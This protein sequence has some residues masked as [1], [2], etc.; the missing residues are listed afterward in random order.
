LVINAAT[1]TYT[2]NA[3]SMTYGSAVPG[4]SGSVS[5]F[6]GTDNQGNAT[7]GTLTFTPATTSTSGVGSYAI[8]GTGL[9]ANNGNYTFVQATGNATA[10]TINALPVNL[11]GTRSYDGTTTAAAGILSVANKVGSDNVTVVSGNGTLAGANV[12]SKAITSLGTLAL[13]GTAA[14]NYTLA[15]ASGSVNITVSALA[16]TVTNL[17]ALDNVYDGTTNATLDATN[18]GL[19]GVLNGDSVTLVVSNAVA[20]F[21]DKNVGTNKPVTVTGLALGSTAAANYTLADPTNVTANITA[22]GLTVNGVAAASKVYDGTTNA[23]LNGTATLNGEVS[24]DDVSLVTDGVNAAFAGP[25]VGTG[26]PVTVRGYAIT[27]ADAGNYTLTQPSALAADITAATLTITATA[28]TKTYD[29]TTSASA[30]PTTSG[31]QGSDTV[32]GLAETYDTK[33]VGTGK[34]LSVNAYTVN[35]GNSGNNYIVNTATSTAGVISKATLTITAT[36]NTKTY[37]GS[38]SAAT[39]PTVSGL[40]GSDTVTGLAETYDTKHAGT[41]KTLSVSAYTVNDSN[42]GNNYTVSTAT[43]TAGVISQASLTITAAANTKTYDC[44]ISASATPT[45]SGLQGSDSVSGLAE[46]YDTKNVGSSKTLSVNAYTVN[47]GNN[48]NNYTVSTVASTAGVINAATLTITAAANTKTYDSSTSAAATPTTSGLQGSD[49]VTGLTE[50]YDTKNVGTGK[51]LSVSAYTVNDGNSGANYTVSTATSIA[52]VISK[53]TLT[54]TATANTKIY[55]GSTSSAATPTVSGLQDS[56]TVTGLAETYDTKNVGTDKTLSVS[57][58]T[59]NDGNNGNNYTVSTATSTAG[60]I[61]KATLTITAAT[62]TKIYDGTTSAA[63]IPTASGLQSSDT[64][65]GLAETYDTK[66]VGSGKTINVSAYTVNDGNAGGNYTVSTVANTA[67]IINQVVLTITAATNTKIYDGSTSAA[68]SPTTSGLQVS[69]SVTGLAETYDTKNVG[70]GKTLSVSAFTVNDGNNG[71]NYTVNTVASTAG[72]I[73]QAFLTITA[74]AN[75][76][77]YDCSISASATPTVSGLQGSDSV[78][79]LAETYDTKNVGS[80]KTLSVNVYTVNDGNSGGN[81]TVSTVASTA[82]VI[83]PAMLTVTADN[84]SKMCGQPNPPLTASYNG[85]VNGE[86][87]NVLTSLVTLATTATTS[88]GAGT[89]P[90]TASGAAAANYTINY[91]GGQLTV[92]SVPQLTGVDINVNGNNLFIISWPTVTG[93]TYQLEYKDDLMAAAWTPEGSSLPGND[94]MAVVTNNI[95]DSPQRFFRVQ[96]Q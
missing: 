47:D 5:G 81:Y 77:T 41:G 12:G 43:S 64:V 17:L 70:T 63:A 51:T 59:V 56:D 60:V 9:T 13:G 32:T 34:T 20:Y 49:S 23:Q 33:D 86:S 16:L 11:T 42:S 21:A 19:A 37:D 6:V 67:G 79:G 10:L 38:T 76:K 28:N 53:A 93:R 58:Y 14:G 72:V 52:G 88:S 46:T 27:G 7:T 24:G 57:A 39:T 91:V 95:S 36:A 55:D 8:N 45:V 40:Q 15:S 1:L 29:G 90:I 74:A 30:T 22:A 26:I 73:S 61:S 65:T 2:A 78:S 71:N 54:I 94:A 4:L 50:T 80:S 35:D 68:A 62:N 31:L 84:K 18:A 3:A 25:N 48:G 44:S 92:D 87:T 75:T 85:F 66:N 89:Y 96:V 83:N 69:D 82:G